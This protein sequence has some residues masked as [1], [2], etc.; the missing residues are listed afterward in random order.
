ML[1]V[2]CMCLHCV[3]RLDIP[4]VLDDTVTI[5]T[6]NELYLASLAV[7]EFI[8]LGWTGYLE[9]VPKELVFTSF[10]AKTLVCCVNMCDRISVCRLPESVYSINALCM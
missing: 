5:T 7:E 4:C 9:C 2:G 1:R 3:I 8:V 6:D 10:S